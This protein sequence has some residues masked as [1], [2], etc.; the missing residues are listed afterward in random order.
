MI[1]YNFDNGPKVKYKI[2]K[3]LKDDCFQIKLRFYFYKNNATE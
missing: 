2:I 3:L 1:S